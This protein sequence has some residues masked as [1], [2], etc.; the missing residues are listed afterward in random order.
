MT[1]KD[2]AER[3]QADQISAMLGSL[4]FG[5]DVP[6]KLGLPATGHQI[7][8]TKGVQKPQIIYNNAASVMLSKEGTIN[9]GP[10]PYGLPPELLQA[11]NSISGSSNRQGSKQALQPLGNNPRI[12]SSASSRS[13]KQSTAN[14]VPMK[15]L[16][17]G[18]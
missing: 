3:V 8:T 6:P 1:T 7:A 5:M 4:T 9:N 2:Y 18:S 13:S 14:S 12:V 17:V 11:R 10:V 16:A 15:T